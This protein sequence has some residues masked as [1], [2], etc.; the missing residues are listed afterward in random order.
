VS[1]ALLKLVFI[2]L[3][4]SPI[5]EKQASILI[6]SIREFG[7][8]YADCPAY[9]FITD[10]INASCKS[11]Y[12]PNVNLIPLFVSDTL[13]NYPFLLKAMACAKAE[14]LLN[15]KA[16]VLVWM[17]VD[18]LVLKEP[19]EFYPESNKKIAIRPVNLRNNVGLLVTDST[20]QYW[21]KVYEYTGLTAEQV[22][23]VESLVDEQKIR[24]YLNC[25]MFSIR[26]ELGIFNEWWRLFLLL[27]Y[28]RDY[29]NSTCI[30]DNRKIFLHQ[31]VLS[32]V[33]ASRI[34]ENE[35]Q[36]FSNKAGYPLHHHNELADEKKA[37]SLNEL[38][39]LI[40]ERLWI[41]PD[42]ITKIILVEEPLKSWLTKEYVQE[43]S[44]LNE[45]YR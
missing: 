16:E 39:S 14:E 36:W 32:A 13:P 25:A 12:S 27:V 43:F 42:S 10:T 15:G 37:G 44:E 8:I 20:D 30:T 18:A 40:Y 23:A 19:D 1:G 21:Q 41:T 29:Q 35:I 5:E 33:I 6:R 3:V 26:P 38:E 31:A 24:L 4:T 7:G 9:I 17:D 28:D 11:I 45:N 34:R 22:P 2:M